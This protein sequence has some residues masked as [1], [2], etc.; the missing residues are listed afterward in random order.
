MFPKNNSH[1]QSADIKVNSIYL[2]EFI[3]MQDLLE[4]K[5]SIILLGGH[6]YALTRQVG[7]L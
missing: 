2:K 3:S 1:V 5:G 4:F 7:L 6:T